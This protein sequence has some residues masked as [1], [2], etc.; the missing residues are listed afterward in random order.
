[1]KTNLGLVWLDATDEERVASTQCLHEHLEG[2]LELSTKSGALL[3]CFGAHFDLVLEQ[4]RNK[5][6][7]GRPNH[8]EQIVA[9]CIAVLLQESGTVVE[10]STSEVDDTERG[11]STRLWLDVVGVSVVV[12]VELA[13]Q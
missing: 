5:H 7:L 11:V 4:A 9:E 3:A 10:H 2:L 1:M 12:V 8:I 13:Q 6:I